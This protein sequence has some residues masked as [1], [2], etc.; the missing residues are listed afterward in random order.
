MKRPIA[1]FRIIYVL[2]W[3]AVI[4]GSFYNGHY[5]RGILA[6]EVIQDY[7]LIAIHIVSA[8]I[9]LTIILLVLKYF[10]LD[11]KIR[12][13]FGSKDFSYIFCNKY[14]KKDNDIPFLGLD[15]KDVLIYFR[16]DINRKEV[17]L[18]ND[19]KVSRGLWNIDSKRHSLF[20]KIEDTETLFQV[21]FL[22]EDDLT[23]VK[24]FSKDEIVFRHALYQ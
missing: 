6:G 8:F 20:V 9:S 17:I 3:F 16:Y 5:Y 11:K 7:Q 1:I 10:G 15:G 18:V 13:C 19:G 4:V 21:K 2:V 14:W 22:S 12:G 24:G 23:L